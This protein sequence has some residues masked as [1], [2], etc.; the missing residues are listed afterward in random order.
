MN[1]QKIEIHTQRL[2]ISEHEDADLNEMHRLLSDKKTM[3]YM[4]DILTNTIAE[5][6]E[7]LEVAIKEQSKEKREKY[8]FKITDLQ[9]GYI[10]EIGFTVVIDCPAG[11]VV[12]L[13]YFILPE[14][15]GNGY[16]TEAAHAL[17]QYSFEHLHVLKFETG[18]LKENIK[19]ERVMVK[20]G[21]TKEADFR[22]HVLHD[23]I[24][25][26]RVEYGLLKE[27]WEFLR[28]QKTGVPRL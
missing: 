11:K 20:L 23:N 27:D 15:W 21:M 6:R 28:I 24:L 13:G 4:Q 14:F 17:I 3:Y 5:S 10:G 2:I 26:D 12:H 9:L 18:C 7:N 8:F 1:P 25:K 16:I 19:S 22:K